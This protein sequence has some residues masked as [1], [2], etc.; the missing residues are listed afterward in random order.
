MDYKQ[1]T[2]KKWSISG[3]FIISILGVA[4]H[5]LYSWSGGNRILAALVPVNES[6]WEHL[7]LGYWS[8]ILFS[9]PEFFSIGKKVNNY[10]F[11][12]F[13]GILALEVCILVIH[14]TYTLLLGNIILWI[15][16]SS[17]VFGV[18]VCQHMVYKLFLT[19]K[20]KKERLGFTGFIS[21]GLL[22]II[23]TYYPP[24]LGIFRDNR[25]GVT[26]GGSD[27]SQKTKSKKQIN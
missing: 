17:F 13:I 1:A 24:D 8:L 19:K 14:Y 6:I 9:I 15:D 16:I 11:A 3:I 4:W 22:F 18:M 26:E 20:L 7:K 5:Y 2:I 27:K 21:L 25:S 10:F 12:K 23:L